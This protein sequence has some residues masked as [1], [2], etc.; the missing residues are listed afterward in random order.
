MKNTIRTFFL[1]TPTHNKG[2]PAVNFYNLSFSFFTFWLKF[3]ALIRFSPYCIFVEFV[4][5]SV[6]LW[7]SSFSFFEFI[8]GLTGIIKI[9]VISCTADMNL[10]RI[11]LYK[12]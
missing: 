3:K 4:E 9:S 2:V 6:L 1:L 11:F 12:T 5:I 8:C 10:G 7:T